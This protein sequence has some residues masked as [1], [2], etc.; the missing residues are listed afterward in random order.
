[1]N[2]IQKTIE[3]RAITDRLSAEYDIDK[4]CGGDVYETVKAMMAL[5]I[6]EAVNVLGGTPRKKR[7]IVTKMAN[8]LTTGAVAVF[9]LGYDTAKKEGGT[10]TSIE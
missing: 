3:V 5:A 2:W 9:M 8:W 6:N 7:R 10:C 1:M 4:V